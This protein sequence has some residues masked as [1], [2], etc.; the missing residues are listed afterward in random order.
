MTVGLETIA[1]SH[2]LSLPG[3]LTTPQA[4][5][6]VVIDGP[7][8]GAS[9]TLDP[10]VEVIVGSDDGCDLTLDDDRVSRRHLSLTAEGPRFV[11]RD[12]ASKNGTLYE[13]SRLGEATLS[14]GAT[15]RLGRSFVRIQPQPQI[16]EVQPSQSRRFGEL[17]AE[18]LSMREVFAVLDLAAMAPDVTVLLEG[19]TGT[20]KELAARAVHEH[21]VRRRKPFVAVDCG[22]LPESLLDSELFGHVRGAFT[23]AN[24]ARKGAFARADGGTVFLDELTQ[25]SPAVQ[26]RLLRVIEERRLRPVGADH[27]QDIDVRVIAAARGDL[28][29]DVKAGTFRPDLY[30]RLSVVRVQLPPLRKRREDIAPIAAELLRRRGI[31]GPVEGDALAR[32]TAHDWP[33]NVRELR[34]VLD[35]A[36]TLSPMARCFS[37]LRIATPG[38]AASGGAIGADALVV[39]SDVAYSEAKSTLLEA[40]ERR[41]LEDVFTRNDG[42]ISATSRESGIDRKHLKVLLR[43]HGLLEG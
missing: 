17:V 35:R 11:A 24:R 30:Y 2:T 20:G 5:Q 31:D 21:S 36:V 37:E 41:Y 22:A 26:A 9:V 18:S 19:E 3:A 33:G 29:E 23:G 39:R 7:D 32:L 13:G 4:A 34:N 12:L 38:L 43:R 14:L 16:I 1:T 8:V 42:N 25:V 6:L 28:A 40:F 27:E 15:L 10:G